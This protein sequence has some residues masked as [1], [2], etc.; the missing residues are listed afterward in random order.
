MAVILFRA[1]TQ[2]K[3]V[4]PARDAEPGKILHEARGGEMAATEPEASARVESN[5]R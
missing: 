3:D 4:N 5:P 2:A 1:D